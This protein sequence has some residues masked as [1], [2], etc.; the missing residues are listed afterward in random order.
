MRI[1]VFQSDIEWC[2]EDANLSKVEHVLRQV[3]GVADI[4]LLPE[5]FTTGFCVEADSLDENIG[6]KT[7]ETLLTW[8]KEYDVAISGSFIAFDAGRYFNRAFFV[9]P[10]GE[11]V[12]YDKRHL[13]SIGAEGKLFSRGE[14]RVIVPFRGWNICL[15]ICYDLRFPVFSRCVNNEY[16]LLLYFANWPKSRI[17]AWNILLPARAV[18]NLS[19]VCGVNRVGC[20]GYGHQQGGASAVYSPKGEKLLQLGSQE[21]FQIVELNLEY[22]RQF[23]EKFPAWKDADEFE[24]S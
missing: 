17:N 20:D 6:G 16:D 3:S 4:L 13:F 5:M 15:Q 11:F 24:I 9:T 2:N 1:A 10:E 12:S 8:S 14:K 23:R 19:Y 7:K 21:E 22:L 18:E